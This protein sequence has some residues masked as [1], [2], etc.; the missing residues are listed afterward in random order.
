MHVDDAIAECGPTEWDWLH[1]RE[2]V[3]VERLRAHIA[4]CPH[5][6]PEVVVVS[7]LAR[8]LQTACGA[9]GA[10]ASV[11]IMRFSLTCLLWCAPLGF[12]ATVYF[13]TRMWAAPGFSS[14]PGC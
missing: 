6:R 2:N 3:Q 10:G 11:C 4:A 1:V 7:P 14:L 5:I 13:P 9:F 8:A 12:R